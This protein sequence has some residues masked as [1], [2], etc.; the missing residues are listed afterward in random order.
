MPPCYVQNH[1]IF[2]TLLR[3]IFDYPRTKSRPREAFELVGGKSAM[4]LSCGFQAQGILLHTPT[5]RSAAIAAW[6]CVWA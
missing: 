1:Q 6:L 2:T 4:H 5:S 3:G